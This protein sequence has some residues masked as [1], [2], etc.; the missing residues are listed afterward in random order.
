LARHLHAVILA[1]P[2]TR[3]GPGRVPGALC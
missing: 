2:D 3:K 1:H